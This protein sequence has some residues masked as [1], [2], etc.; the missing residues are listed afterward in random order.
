V[1][2]SCVENDA[3]PQPLFRLLFCPVN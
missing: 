2:L 3:Y 1:K